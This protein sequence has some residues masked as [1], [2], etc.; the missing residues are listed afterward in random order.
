M[1]LPIFL[2]ALLV[3]PEKIYDKNAAVELAS[4]MTPDAPFAV[5]ITAD[6]GSLISTRNPQTEISPVCRDEVAFGPDGALSLTRVDKR[7]AT[8]FASGDGSVLDPIIIPLSFESYFHVT[9]A[10]LSWTGTVFDLFFTQDLGT[11]WH[12]RFGSQGQMIGEPEVLIP[13]QDL[14]M[15]VSALVQTTA[16]PLLFVHEFRLTGGLD[17]GAQYAYAV[18]EDSPES[19]GKLDA[20]DLAVAVGG[21]SRLFAAWTSYKDESTQVSNIGDLD[22]NGNPIN[23]QQLEI[24]TGFFDRAPSV[25]WD[26][27]NFIIATANGQVA[28]VANGNETPHFFSV[29][30]DA[31][32]A[33]MISGNGHAAIVYT[34][35]RRREKGTFYRLIY[36]PRDRPSLSMIDRR[37][38]HR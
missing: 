26:G 35:T 13:D 38:H 3:G 25:G 16:G 10:K 32:D 31:Y 33:R 4:L 34:A 22:F 14:F 18:N 27:A 11:I 2:A 1:L 29:S 20:N 9:H 5:F 28:A 37:T 19:V 12:V 36:T 17:P 15:F 23:R 30:D 24:D 7:L 6:C 8:V 21:G